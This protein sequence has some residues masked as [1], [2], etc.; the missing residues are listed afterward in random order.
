MTS[1]SSPPAT[2]D[3]LSGYVAAMRATF[4][5]AAAAGRSLAIQ[6]TFT[7]RVSGVCHAC[8]TNS[9]LTAGL[10]P[11]PAPDVA[12]TAD[13]DLWRR[14]LAHEVDGLIAW[15]EGRYTTTGDFEALMESDLW[16]RR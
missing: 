6:Y 11:T 10:G 1:D 13:F 16:F 9:A 15:Q 4:D 3:D 8:I 7:G 14:I 12:V 2:H 5:P